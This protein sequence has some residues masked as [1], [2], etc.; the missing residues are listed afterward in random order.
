MQLPENPLPTP[1]P[2]DLATL[3]HLRDRHHPG[4]LE[5]PAQGEKRIV[6][7]CLKCNRQKGRESHFKA[8]GKM[9]PAGA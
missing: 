1:H 8:I 7:A 3:E 5:P 9:L 2:N 4:R 6:L